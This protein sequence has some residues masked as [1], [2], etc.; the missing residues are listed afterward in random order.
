LLAFVSAC[1]GPVPSPEDPVRSWLAE[2]ERASRERDIGAMKD[3][4]SRSYRDRH[5]RTQED[6]HG[7][8][9]FQYFRQNSVYL[10]TRIESL[11]LPAP[12]RARLTVLGA[13]AGSPLEGPASLRQVRADVYRFELE[14][15]DE[16]DQWRV[17]SGDWRPAGVDDFL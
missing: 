9:T 5:G 3:L 1:S 12:S 11:D 6:V 16:G 13:M 17:V 14:L 15:V 7:I 10:L 8:I 4:I 2:A